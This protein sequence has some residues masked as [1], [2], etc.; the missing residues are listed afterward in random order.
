MKKKLEAEGHTVIRKDKS[1]NFMVADFEKALIDI[2]CVK[3]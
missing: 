2:K 3:F 1:K